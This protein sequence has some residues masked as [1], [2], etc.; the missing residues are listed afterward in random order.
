MLEPGGG[1]GLHLPDA[2]AMPLEQAVHQGGPEPVGVQRRRRLGKGLPD[3]AANPF[4][5]VTPGLPEG[6][7]SPLREERQGTDQLQNVSPAR[8]LFHPFPPD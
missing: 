5:S 2:P 6:I 7:P 4:G 8:T 1:E 3:N